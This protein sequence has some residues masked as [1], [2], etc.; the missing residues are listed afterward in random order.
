MRAVIAGPTSWSTPGSS[1]SAAS[2]VAAVRSRTRA[3][4]ASSCSV[5]AARSPTRSSARLRPYRRTCGYPASSDTRTTAACAPPPR[6]PSLLLSAHSEFA[7]PAPTRRRTAV[8]ARGE[9]SEI[10]IPLQR[11]RREQRSQL[12]RSEP[13]RLRDI[14]RSRSNCRGRRRAPQHRRHRVVDPRTNI[15]NYEKISGISSGRGRR[16]RDDDDDDARVN[17]EEG[18]DDAGARRSVHSRPAPTHTSRGVRT[19]EFR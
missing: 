2:A 16:A 7:V 19:L 3:S 14:C 11:A 17:A 10:L 9:G 8:F 12:G 4:V 13:R 15:P 1:A 18:D 5:G 6:S